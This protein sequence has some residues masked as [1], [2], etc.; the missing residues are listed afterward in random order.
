MDVTQP[1][2]F[3]KTAMKEVA[4]SGSDSEYSDLL[5]RKSYDENDFHVDPVPN[6]MELSPEILAQLQNSNGEI[7]FGANENT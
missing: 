1:L 3:E 7:N 6:D 4:S 5:G 2:P